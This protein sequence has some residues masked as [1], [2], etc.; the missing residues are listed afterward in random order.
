MKNKTLEFNQKREKALSDLWKKYTPKFSGKLKEVVSRG[1]VFSK[2]DNIEN[3][4]LITGINP[5]FRKNGKIE[6]SHYF[7]FNDIEVQNDYY[8][9]KIKNT[10]PVLA[11]K[12]NIEYTDLFYFRQTE[13]VK[14]KDF[15]DDK[16]GINFLVEQLCITK[17]F[18]EELKP[19]LI[20]VFNKGSWAFWGKEYNSKKDTLTWLGYDFK[21]IETLNLYEIVGLLN[22]KEI[23][24]NRET[25]LKGHKIYFSKSLKYL[26]NIEL[27]GIKEDLREVFKTI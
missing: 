23:I 8:Y 1:Y 22:S 26:S 10:L 18:I 21:Q 16:V 6:A 12:F 4:V 14:L 3:I 11:S 27:E 15:F 17:S 13:Q 20:I 5:S 19:K 25:S 2:V 24:C 9:R 7:K